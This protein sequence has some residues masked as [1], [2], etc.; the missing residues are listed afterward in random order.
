MSYHKR[1]SRKK[2]QRQDLRGTKVPLRF[3]ADF[4]CWSFS[5]LFFCSSTT[6]TWVVLSH[7]NPSIDLSFSSVAY[8]TVEEGFEQRRRQRSSL[9]FGGQNLFK[10][11]VSLAVLHQDDLKKRMNSSF[12]AY[13]PGGINPLFVNIII[14]SVPQKAATT[15]AFSSV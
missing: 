13:H 11:L 15:F 4:R 12:S 6:A 10:F 2:E 5:K 7:E 8:C 1:C 3:P 9:L 14:K